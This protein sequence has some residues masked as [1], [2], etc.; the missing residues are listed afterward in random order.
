MQNRRDKHLHSPK[1]NIIIAAATG[2]DESA[3]LPFM[4]SVKEHCI[5]TN[6]YLIVYE[7]QKEII[8]ILQAKFNFTIPYYIDKKLGS[9]Y[10]KRKLYKLCT[11]YISKNKYSPLK[12]GYFNK[13]LGFVGR[14][15]MHISVERYFIALEILRTLDLS[16]K[17]VMLT[18]I[19]D[20]LIQR[21]PFDIIN[22]IANFPKYV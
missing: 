16:A 10:F 5:D 7:T 2:Y 9:K 19:R 13:F 1:K 20:V 22:T 4:E 14:Q 21:N 3:I 12:A 8:D 11:E 17:N 18:D 15:K 6:I